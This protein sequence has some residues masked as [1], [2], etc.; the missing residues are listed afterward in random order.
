MTRREDDDPHTVVQSPAVLT[1]PSSSGGGGGEE[2]DSDDERM[3]TAFIKSFADKIQRAPE[4]A[5]IKLVI[6]KRGEKDF[7]PLAEGARLQEMMLQNSRQALFDALV[8]VRGGSGK[9]ISHALLAPSSPYPYLVVQRGHVLD[10]MGIT[11]RSTSGSSSS[12]SAQTPPPSS[13]ATDV[14]SAGPSSAPAPA[15]T[16]AKKGRIHL[17]PEEA[18]YLLERGSLQIWVGPESHTGDDGVGEWD[19]AVFGVRGAVEV[20]VQ[21]GFGYFVGRDGLTWERYQAYAALKRLGYTV[22]RTRRFLPAFF[23][24]DAAA[25]ADAQLLPPFRTWWLSLPLWIAAM[26]RSVVRAARRAVG[27]IASVGLG[28]GLGLGLRTRDRPLLAGWTGDSYASILKHLRIVPSGHAQPVP[29]VSSA[30]A[31]SA[32]AASLSAAPTAPVAAPLEE[33]PYAPLERNPYLPFFHVWKPAT[34]WAKG[35]WD[36]G[37]AAGLARQRPEFSVAVVEARN[38]PIPTLQQLAEIF[39]GLPDEPTGPVVKLGPQYVRPPRPPRVL[40]KPR[41]AETSSSSRAR[42]WAWA[43]RVAPRLAAWARTRAEPT[44]P[45]GANAAMGRLRNGDRA[46]VVAV[47]DS[48]NTGWVRFGRAG[49]ADYPVI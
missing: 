23:L 10:S 49:F 47:N 19:D 4:T 17:L 28:L 48:G 18:L 36:R 9:T 26:A 44:R 25:P 21:E 7:E 27:R 16:A 43:E 24:A 2:G 35:K 42:F 31:V 22:Q 30:S 41:P 33:Q 14:P 3:D 5:R 39:D 40:H 6:P 32:P 46:L 20:S 34:S 29:P 45:L 1:Q 11:V 37:S 12:S 38:T 15:S 13:L 8:G